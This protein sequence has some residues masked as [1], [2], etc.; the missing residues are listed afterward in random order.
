MWFVGFFLYHNVLL[1]FFFFGR[2]YNARQGYI[3]LINSKNG[4]IVKYYIITIYNSCFLFE[5]I[6]KCNLFHVTQSWD[7]SIITP[8]FSV[9]WSFRNHS[10]MLICCSIIIIIFLLLLSMLTTVMLLHIFVVTEILFF[11]IPWS[12]ESKKTAFI[13]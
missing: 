9:T 7:F 2:K 8:V 10:N 5:Y 4:N 12:I 1:F 13:L 3:C 6:L 11:K